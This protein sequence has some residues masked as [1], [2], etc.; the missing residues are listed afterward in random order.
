[1]LLAKCCHD[2]DWIYDIFGKKCS[3]IQSF[4]TLRHF[5]KSE[6]PAGA[7]DRCVDCPPR[8]ESLCPYSA[9]KYYFRNRFSRGLRGWPTSVLT[10]GPETAEKLEEALTC[11]PYGR[12]VYACDNDVVDHQVVNMSFEDGTTAA[13]TMTAFNFAGG[14]KT[15][16]FGTRGEIDTDSSII[17]IHNFLHDTTRAVDINTINDGGINS[18]HGGGDF[19][20]MDCFVSAVA[21]GDRKCII[22]GV[23]NT[24]NSHLLVFAAEKSRKEN[25]VVFM[26]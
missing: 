9:C 5:K 18:G 4:G 14:R 25:T 20:L 21:E 24:L 13:M 15:R 19:G 7:A 2:I 23:D 10:N 8:I 1:M 22:S 17:T 16:I 6:Q 11:G 26:D 12:C 3:M